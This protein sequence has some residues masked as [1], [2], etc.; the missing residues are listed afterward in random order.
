VEYGLDKVAEEPEQVDPLASL[1]EFMGSLGKGEYMW[2][3]L[4]VRVHKGEHYDT[5]NEAGKA[6]TWKDEAKELVQSIRKEASLKSQRYDPGSGKIVEVEGHPNPTKGQVE[7]IAAIE[8][9][10]SKLAFDVGARIVYLGKPGHFSGTTIPGIIGI[11]KQ[12]SSE[13]LN[14]FK[15]QGWM[16]IFNDYPWERLVDFRKNHTRHAL[17]EA[18]RRRSY[19]HQPFMGEYMTMSTEELA[20]IYHIP[21]AATQTPSLPRIPSATSNAPV[22]LPT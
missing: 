21:S 1:L 9:N 22:N 19:F 6:Y 7:T 13:Q 20:T 18:Y 2:L 12:F 14:G 8:R 3:Q 11:F 10:I 17:V 4:P 15:P 16:T 5:L